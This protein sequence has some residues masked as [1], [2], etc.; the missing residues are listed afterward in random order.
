VKKTVLKF[1][2]F[3]FHLCRYVA[4]RLLDTHDTQMLLVPLL[5][6]RPWVRRRKASGSDKPVSVGL[7]KL[8]PVDP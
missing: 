3:K 7:Y 8:N 5:E 6:E 1:V 2:F 4:A